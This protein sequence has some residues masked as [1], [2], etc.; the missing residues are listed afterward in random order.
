MKNITLTEKGQQ[1]LLKIKARYNDLK[2]EYG[3]NALQRVVFENGEVPASMIIYAIGN[4]T[5]DDMDD[6]VRQGYARDE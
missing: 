3:Q 6:L 5:Q 4:P 1:A 2:P